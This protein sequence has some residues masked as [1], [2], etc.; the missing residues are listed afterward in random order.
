VLQLL[1]NVIK[2]D[3][4]KVLKSLRIRLSGLFS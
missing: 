3:K 4:T 1:Y 2:S